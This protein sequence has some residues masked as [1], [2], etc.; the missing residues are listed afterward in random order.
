MQTMIQCNCGR[1]TQVVH[2]PACGSVNRYPLAV[3]NEVDEQTGKLYRGYRCRRCGVEYNDLDRLAC[4]APPPPL[5]KT[6]RQAIARAQGIEQFRASKGI[7]GT[8]DR[9][10]M[11]Q[12][13][14]SK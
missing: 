7:D 11:L 12:K 3:K 10:T 13:L 5:S 8:E 6:E 1:S 14:F 4:S 9:K 2:C